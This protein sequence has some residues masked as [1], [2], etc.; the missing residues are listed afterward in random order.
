MVRWKAWLEGHEFD[1]KSLVEVFR[2]G[3]P[4]VAKDGSEGFYVQS[5]VLEG[6]DGT[7]DFDAA[8]TLVRRMNGIGRAV[9]SSFR[10]VRL[11]GRYTSPDGKVSHVVSADTAEARFSGTATAVVAGADPVPAPPPKG[12]RYAKVAEEDADVA[13]VLRILG[14]ADPLDWY[15]LYKVWEILEQAVGGWKQVENQGWVTKPAINRFTA[16]ADHPGLSGDAARHA[17]VKGNSPRS[18]LRMPL[19]EADAMM[20]RLAASWI[21]SH[22]ASCSRS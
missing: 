6:L 8:P 19:S 18:A 16:S 10:P 21:E 15:D 1:L 14:Q 9:D 7:P 4:L 2:E 11:V 20:R 22:P 3:E 12:P 17:R 5:Q 13:D